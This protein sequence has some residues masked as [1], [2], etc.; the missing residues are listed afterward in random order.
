MPAIHMIYGVCFY[1]EKCLVTG[2]NLLE[3]NQLMKCTFQEN[4][5]RF[6]QSKKVCGIP[7]P[8]Y[9]FIQILFN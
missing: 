6:L 8:F 3:T 7:G 5:Y 9:Y 4:H 2:K 1:S